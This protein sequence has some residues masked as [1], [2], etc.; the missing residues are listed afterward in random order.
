M[1]QIRKSITWPDGVV[2]KKFWRENLNGGEQSLDNALAYMADSKQ[3]MD[4]K[5]ENGGWLPE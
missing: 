3:R 4:L 2:D 1:F 5:V